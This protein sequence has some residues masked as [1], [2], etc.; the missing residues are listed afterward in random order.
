MQVFNANQLVGKER[1]EAPCTL[2]SKERCQKGKGV[3]IVC[4]CQHRCL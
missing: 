1:V 3:Q 2:A 4:I